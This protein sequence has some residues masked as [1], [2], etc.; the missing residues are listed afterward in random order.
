MTHRESESRGSRT[1]S[2]LGNY[3]A[4]AVQVACHHHPVDHQA[5]CHQE[6]KDW[7]EE[8][9]RHGAHCL[10]GHLDASHSNLHA[11]TDTE[12]ALNPGPIQS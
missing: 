2:G 3:G 7:E 10:A 1:R 4:S 9:T 8:Q 6:G 5:H 11:H 12:L